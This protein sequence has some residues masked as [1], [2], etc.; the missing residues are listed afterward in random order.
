MRRPKKD[1][2]TNRENIMNRE[3]RRRLKKR[4]QKIR[5]FD[6]DHNLEQLDL[7]WKDIPKNRQI[8][9][10]KFK[11]LLKEYK[12]DIH[13]FLQNGNKMMLKH[14]CSYD[15]HWLDENIYNCLHF[16]LELQKFRNRLSFEQ[17]LQIVSIF[18]N[19]LD[20]IS[21]RVFVVHS[22]VMF[23]FLKPNQVEMLDKIK[24]E[25]L[26]R[27][28]YDEDEF[29][30]REE[31]YK[32]FIQNKE[33]Q[34]LPPSL[35]YIERMNEQKKVVAK[36]KSSNLES[37]FDNEDDFD[38][39]YDDKP[40]V[41]VYR[42][43]AVHEGE[44]IR[45]LAAIEQSPKNENILDEMSNEVK[46]FYNQ[47]QYAGRGVSYTFDKNI[48]LTFAFRTMNEMRFLAPHDIKLRACVAEYV[49]KKEDIFAYCN[50]R[51]EREIIVN[52]VDEFDVPVA[53][54]NYEFFTN[55]DGEFD[56]TGMLSQ[57][58]FRK[59][60]YEDYDDYAKHFKNT[61]IERVFN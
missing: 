54:A 35:S 52:S 28:D 18:A 58:Q 25:V 53:L 51:S 56:K 47:S 10:L 3:Q 40:Y 6:Y 36:I 15:E 23:D 37:S 49:V 30:E 46:D 11:R 50:G 5:L 1:F 33:L 20:P 55:E 14:N 44:C 60:A 38:A 61:K 57:P 13:K 26:S 41:V 8:P 42:G 7:E 29:Y 34:N 27:K 4:V 43:F 12:F 17:I 31:L 19:K 2:I 45:K 24:K 32:A 16:Y 48:A 22:L 21:A 9:A 39:Y 59:S